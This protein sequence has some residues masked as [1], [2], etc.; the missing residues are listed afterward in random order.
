MFVVVAEWLRSP[1]S[2]G[3]LM[4]FGTGGVANTFS[5]QVP[6]SLPWGSAPSSSAGALLKGMAAPQLTGLA[7]VDW[8]LDPKTL[9]KPKTPRQ[10]IYVN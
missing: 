4:V 3:D 1:Y 10:I 7:C 5:C 6:T 2:W 8:E 9:E